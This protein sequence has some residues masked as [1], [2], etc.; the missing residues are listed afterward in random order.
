MSAM[1][2]TKAKVF[3]KGRRQRF[4]K[5]FSR[6]ELKKAGLSLTEALRLRVPVDSRRRSAYDENVE[7]VKAFLAGRVATV[8]AEAKPKKKSK[9]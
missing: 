2:E 3:R 5:G 6:E 4:G 1:M 8:K 7:A 9:R